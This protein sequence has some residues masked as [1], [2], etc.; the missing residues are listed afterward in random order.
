[1][2]PEIQGAMAAALSA[3]AFRLR[4]IATGEQPLAEAVRHGRYRDD[5][6]AMLS[7]ITIELPPLARRREDIPLL[8]QALLEDVNAR[9]G[10]QLGSFAPETLDRLVAYDW[11]GNTDEL[12][13]VVAESCGRAAGVVILPDDLPERLRLA[14]E[15]AARPRRKEETIRLD[16]FIARIERELIRRALARAKGNKAKAAR[17]LGLNRP[18]LYRR[19][20]QLGLLDEGETVG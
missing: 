13:E 10:R 2:A 16:E 5:L 12:A 20:I 4:S 18:R 8:A 14:A 15:A 11:P 7:T 1:M 3:P 17:L 6:A 9:G 19:M